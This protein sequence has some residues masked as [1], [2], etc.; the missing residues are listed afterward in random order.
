MANV[1]IESAFRIIPVAPKDTPL[2][3]FCWRDQFY[4]DTVLPMGC[5]IVHARFLNDLA[6]P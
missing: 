1:D 6:Q 5:A 2:L 4:M 3:G